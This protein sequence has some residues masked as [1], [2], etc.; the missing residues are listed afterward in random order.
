MSKPSLAAIRSSNLAARWSYRPTAM[1]VGATSGIGEGTA[2]AF[3]QATKGRAHIIILGR[4]REC[5]DQIIASFP[6]TPESRYDFIQCDLSLM[7]NVVAAANEAKSKIEG[8]LNYL[9]LSQGISHAKGFTPTSEGI[10]IKLALHFYSRWKFV[11]ELHPLLEQ[12]AAEGQAA[13]ILNVMDPKK[14]KPI[15]VTDFGLKKDYSIIR[16]AHQNSAYNNVMVEEYS[17]RYPTLSIAH[18]YPGWVKTGIARYTPMYAKPVVAGLRLLCKSPEECGE[19]MLSALLNE[20][21][22]Q[23]GFYLEEFGQEIEV[24]KDGEE[25]QK[26]LVEHYRK[27]TDL[28][29]PA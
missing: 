14:T 22:K 10:D 19:W 29:P 18:V 3:A 16:C 15:D 11:D 1:F 8:P 4:S 26:S 20:K 2:K 12:A 28:S 25:V 5:A 9:V 21:Y 17:R 7:T 6:Q 23:G 27:E 13:R 24:R